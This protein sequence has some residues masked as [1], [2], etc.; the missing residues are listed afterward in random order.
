MNIPSQWSIKTKPYRQLRFEAIQ[1]C[2][3]SPFGE[4]RKHNI[5]LGNVNKSKQYGHSVSVQEGSWFGILG[6]AQGLQGNTGREAKWA[7]AGDMQGCGKGQVGGQNTHLEYRAVYVYPLLAQGWLLGH[8]DF[9]LGHCVRVGEEQL[10]N[11]QRQGRKKRAWWHEMKKE[12]IWEVDYRQQMPWSIK[13]KTESTG[14][15]NYKVNSDPNRKR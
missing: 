11:G 2:L 13:I 6:S 10:R 12:E 3:F 8:W 9:A 4:I 1:V 7:G 14:L 5:S 15:V